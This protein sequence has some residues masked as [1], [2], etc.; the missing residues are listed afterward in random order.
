[1][2][3]PMSAIAFI[4]TRK[5]TQLPNHVALAYH[6]AVTLVIA[7]G[8]RVRTG[9]CKGSDQESVSLALAQ[10]G[11]A[12]LVLPWRTYESA[13][14]FGL[15]KHR[16][17]VECYDPKA[18]RDWTDS[19][20]R[21]HPAPHALTRGAVALHARNFGIVAPCLAVIAAPRYRHG[22]SGGTGQGMRI[23]Q[24]L[25]LPVFDVNEATALVALR[26][27]LQ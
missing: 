12:E 17:S 20:Y 10:D 21:Y 9:A 13:W 25:G 5:F 2:S 24:A 11:Q 7:R 8:H 15:P 23:A 14:V 16:V 6:D 26:Q 22:Q 27:W 4:G 18:N 3:M 19:V 1:M